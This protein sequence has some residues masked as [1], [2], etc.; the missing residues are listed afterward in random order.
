MSS[1]NELTI[2]LDSAPMFVV[3]IRFRDHVVRRFGAMTIERRPLHVSTLVDRDRSAQH[4]EEL[5]VASDVVSVTNIG[6]KGLQ[7]PTTTLVRLRPGLM[8]TEW[9]DGADGA[10]EAELE[11]PPM[12]TKPKT[13]LD[14]ADAVFRLEGSQLM[15]L[16]RG[17]E[18]FVATLSVN[19]EA[20]ETISVFCEAVCELHTMRQRDAA[21]TAACEF[22]S[23]L[24]ES[25][26]ADKSTAILLNVKVGEY[27]GR[28]LH[29]FF[30]NAAGQLLYGP[31]DQCQAVCDR[32]PL[33]M[34]VADVICMGYRATA[35]SCEPLLY[36]ASTSLTQSENPGEP[37]PSADA[38]ASRLHGWHKRSTG[39]IAALGVSSNRGGS[40]RSNGSNSGDDDSSGT[41]DCTY[42]DGCSTPKA[43]RRSSMRQATHSPAG[44][45]SEPMR[46][47]GTTPAS[48]PLSKSFKRVSYSDVTEDP[49]P[50][51]QRAARTHPGGAQ[52]DG[53]PPISPVSVLKHGG[54]G[55]KSLQISCPEDRKEF[56]PTCPVKAMP[57]GSSPSPTAARSLTV[58]ME[59]A[60]AVQA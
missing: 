9:C 15:G 52:P 10:S 29:T 43:L 34:C 56:Q 7:S 2:R 58:E 19:A 53:A 50:F 5:F 31:G 12:K 57:Q 32:P 26:A 41:I 44:S 8:V 27:Q 42:N 51:W 39:L 4:P 54:D 28:V 48:S 46:R 49:S 35:D 36:L 17:P 20:E 37:P 59:K 25:V 18:G 13:L 23:P 30:K 22:V 45:F 14:P 47:R 60:V 11:E 6:P 16:R 21:E 3:A 24:G 55:F 1:V 33:G 40:F 38:W